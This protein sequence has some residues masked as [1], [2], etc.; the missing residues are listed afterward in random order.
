MRVGSRD[1]RLAVPSRAR[2]AKSRL[3]GERQRRAGL[4]EHAVQRAGRAA[5]ARRD[6]AARLVEIDLAV[7]VIPGIDLGQ[8]LVGAAGGRGAVEIERRRARELDAAGSAGASGPSSCRPWR[9][10]SMAPERARAPVPPRSEAAERAAG[11]RCRCRRR[12]APSGR[13]RAAH[14]RGAAAGRPRRGRTEPPRPAAPRRWAR[15]CA[16][17]DRRVAAEAGRGTGAERQGGA[18]HR[19]VAGEISVIVVLEF[20]AAPLRT[21]ARIGLRLPGGI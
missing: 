18:Q 8:V 17:R 3:P 7:A 10:G 1:D 5:Q 20:S 12:A 15:R 19:D 21:V 13:W 11:R 2:S 4:G 14:R 16:P 9:C 6:G